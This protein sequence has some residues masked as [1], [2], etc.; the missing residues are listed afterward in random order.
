MTYPDTEV[1]VIGAGVS[2][3]STAL[4]LLDSGLTVSIYAAGLPHRVTSGAAGA[5]WGIHMVGEDERING[6][7]NQSF[8]RFRSLA[9]DPRTGIHEISGVEAYLDRLPEPPLL[10]TGLD[11]LSKADPH[12]L[13]ADYRAG[14][15]YRAP[16]IAMPEYLDYLVDQV[17]DGGGLLQ[18]GRPLLS[19]DHAAEYSP[20]RI[21]VNCTGIGAR[22]F[23]PDDAMVPVRG[24][25]V[26]VANPGITEFFIGERI[27]P[28]E[29]TY[30]FPHGSTAVLGGTEQPGNASTA[31]DPAI[32]ARIVRAC[33]DIEPKLATAP[34]LGHRVGL[35]PARPRVRLETTRLASGRPVVHNYGHGGAGVTLSWGCAQS[36]KAEILA[37]LA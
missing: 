21:I 25:I 31:P 4:A 26:V 27:E 33:A 1:L 30:I 11:S 3:L 22:G 37:V 19:L 17:I 15:R 32:A 5:L 23:V 8:E 2:G 13:P 12:S 20:A 6:W 34:V 14:W 7:A 9:E 10:P 35:R 16:I 18:V 28:D 36:V 29:I 24:Q